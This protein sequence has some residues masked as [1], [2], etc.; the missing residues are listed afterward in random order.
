MIEYRLQF[1]AKEGPGGE[2]TEKPTAK[3]LE[4]ARKDG[5][6]SALLHL[7]MEH[8]GPLD[9]YV[10]LKDTKVSTKFYV[11]NDAILDYLEANM[12]VL[13]ERLQKRGYDCKCETTLRTE[14][15]QTA[16][17]MAPLLKTEGSVPVAQ[18]AFDVRT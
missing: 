5:Q 1:F 6:V 7:D 16:Q 18:Y 11:Q 9:V 12:D 3:K 14:L 4:D 13:T 15:Q 2:K 8:L 10:T 17:A